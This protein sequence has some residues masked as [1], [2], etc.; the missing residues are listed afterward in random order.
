MASVVG[1][2]NGPGLDGF[3]KLHGHFKAAIGDRAG[4]DDL[5]K[6]TLG[7]MSV[8]VHVQAAVLAHRQRLAQQERDTAERHIARQ[9]LVPGIGKRAVED[10]ERRLA[11]QRTALVTA[12]VA[13]ERAGQCD[14]WMLLW[15]RRLVHRES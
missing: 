13:V 3:A 15:S 9:H 6:V 10:G 1:F 11:L 5:A 14:R 12:T 2:T 7:R 8:A 4:A